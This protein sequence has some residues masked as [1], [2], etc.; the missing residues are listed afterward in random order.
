MKVSTRGRYGLRA[1]I[2]IAV[3]ENKG[4]IS[5]RSIAEKENISEAYLEQIMVPLKKA[6]LVKS[7]RGSSGGYVLGKEADEIKVGDIFRTLE[8]S[9]L[10]SSCPEEKEC[11][12]EG[13]DHCVS[14]SVWSKMN[15]SL[16]E[17]VDSIT[18]GDLARDYVELNSK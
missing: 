12:A 4:N 8:G 16:I 11:R 7:A 10:S 6:G 14:K 17:T 3:F 2:N 18:L 1:M 15:E 9:I 13:C 5:L